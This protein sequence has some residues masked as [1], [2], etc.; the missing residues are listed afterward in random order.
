MLQTFNT[1]LQLLYFS[2]Y[3]QVLIAGAFARDYDEL[4]GMEALKFSYEQHNSC[5]LR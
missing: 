1:S 2:C 4:V 5:E 3:L